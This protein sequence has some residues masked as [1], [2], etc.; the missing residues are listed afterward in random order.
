MLDLFLMQF[1]TIISKCQGK[2]EKLWG[3]WLEC[4]GLHPFVSLGQNTIP[5]AFK[6]FLVMA[7]SL[8]S[9]RRRGFIQNDLGL[10]TFLRTSRSLRQHQPLQL[11]QHCPHQ[12]QPTCTPTKKWHKKL[13]KSTK[14]PTSPQSNLATRRLTYSVILNNI[15]T[16]LFTERRCLTICVYH[17]LKTK[18]LFFAL[19]ISALGKTKGRRIQI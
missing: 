5:P 11:I 13:G 7:I 16:F 4:I 18:D 8:G 6:T 15:P 10:E 17:I 1:S 14:Q 19:N 2:E 9:D 12:N 3:E